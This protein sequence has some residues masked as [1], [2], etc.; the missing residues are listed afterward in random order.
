M[1]SLRYPLLGVA[2]WMLALW[3]LPLSGCAWLSACADEDPPVKASSGPIKYRILEEGTYSGYPDELETVCRDA[4]SWKR[5]Y[6]VHR[7]DVQAPTINFARERV[8]I[9]VNQ[10]LTGGYELRFDHLEREAS[11]SLVFHYT[12]IT[13]SPDQFTIQVLT[14]PY[15][16]V[17][18][19]Q[20]SERLRFVRDVQTPTRK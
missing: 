4:V 18:L 14:Q 15:L 3:P 1:G 19:P 20:G 16:I 6:Q 5:F 17:V 2:V 11:G 13:P 9:V 7:P 10:R 12:E 8:A